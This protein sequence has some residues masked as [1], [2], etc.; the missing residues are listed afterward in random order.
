MIIAIIVVLTIAFALLW[1]LTAKQ[2]HSD[3]DRNQQNIDILRQ[4]FIDLKAQHADG[5]LTEAQYQQAYDELVVTLSQDLQQDDTETGPR[6]ELGQ[7]KTLFGIFV[8]LAVLTPALYYLLGTPAALHPH[9]SQA[10]RA[11]HEVVGMNNMPSINAM[12]ERLRQKLQQQPNDT[13]GWMM[14]GRSYIVLRQYDKAADALSRA[15]A[16]KS[17]DPTVLLM[18]ADALAMQNGGTIN[19]KAFTLVKR[20]LAKDPNDPTAMW[21]AAMAYEAQSDYKSALHYWQRLLPKVKS[22]PSDY[23]EVRM[24]V[25]HAQA[26]LSG[27]PMVLPTPVDAPQAG[28][29]TTPQTKHPAVRVTAVIKLASKYR[30]KV[31]PSATVFVYA[32]AVNGPALPLAAKKLQVKDLPATVTLDD[33]MAMSPKNKLSNYTRIYIGARVS[34]SGNA[35]PSRGD[36]QGRSGSVATKDN[37]AIEVTIDKEVM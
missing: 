8:L 31:K 16:Q 15:Y 14:L 10:V 3:R 23:Q 28:A 22:N 20:V 30:N 32:R 29:T 26:R 2:R 18:Y 4:E 34:Q 36:L 6:F 35:M 12:V 25:A 5:E 11:G 21:M 33:S 19:G 17:D 27:K 37:K 9:S 1:F 13:R 24:H 7:G